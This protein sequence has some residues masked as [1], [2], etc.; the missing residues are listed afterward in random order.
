M[1]V[2]II[3]ERLK[4]YAPTSQRDELNAIKEIVQ[5]IALCALARADFFKIAAF[6]GGSCLRIVHKLNRFSEDLDFILLKSDSS[7]VWEPFLK[8]LQSEFKMYSF[9][10]QTID[11]S[12]A[13]KAIKMAFLKDNSFGKILVLTHPRGPSDKQTIQIKLEIDTNPPYGSGFQSH[14]LDFPYAYSITVQ[15]LSS[16]FASKLHAILCQPYVKGRDWFDFVWYVS[17]N[18]VPN[19]MHLQKSIEQAGPWKNQE[20]SVTSEWL[21]SELNNKISKIDWQ[22]TKKDVE[23][24]LR[25]HE[26]HSLAVWGYDFFIATVEKLSGYLQK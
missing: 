7:F 3:E 9:D 10:F 14:F 24:F 4:E 16:L 19:Y 2:K 26:R 5:E 13:D 8:V 18:I 23:N 12:K 11:R 25:T 17:K 6:Q 22:E 20:I 21:I 15:D 1:N